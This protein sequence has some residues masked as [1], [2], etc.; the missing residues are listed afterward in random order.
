MWQY[1]LHPPRL[2]N[3]ATLPC[4]SRNTENVILQW[5]ITKENCIKCIIALSKWANVTCLKFTYLGCCTA[6]LVWNSDSWY[7]QPAKTLD[8]NL[9]WLW[10]GHYRC[11]DWAVERSS[12][13]MCVLVANTLN[14]CCEMNV[15]LYHSSEHF[16]K[17]SMSFD[18]CRPIGDFV[19]KIKSWS[20][21]HVNFSCF[22]FHKVV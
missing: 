3:I 4:E 11:Y 10:T 5:K 14:T 17:P 15:H 21:V 13:T 22:N 6:M 18:A 8:A 2:I 9:V 7:R 1:E 16:M 20:C 19:V 12:E